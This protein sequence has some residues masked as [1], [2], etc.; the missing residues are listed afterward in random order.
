MRISDWSSDV[1][2]SD[3]VKHA[4]GGAIKTD[5]RGIVADVGDDLA[6]ERFQIDPGAGGDFAGDNGNAGLDQ[7]L[8]GDTGALVL[9]KDG[10]EHGIGN[11]IGDFEIG[12]AS[13]RERVGKSE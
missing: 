7:R 8:T 13:C 12:R 2:S 1:C 9:R 6:G 11:L 3:L 10:V 4:A 5:I